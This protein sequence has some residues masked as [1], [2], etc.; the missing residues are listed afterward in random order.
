MRFVKSILIFFISLIT[1]NSGAIN[2][3]DNLYKEFHKWKSV[4]Q[5]D[6][7]AMSPWK[8][9]KQLVIL[10]EDQ[11]TGNSYFIA[12]AD[13]KLIGMSVTQG[14]SS[15]YLLDINMDSI[16]DTKSSFFYMSYKFI[17]S[18]TKIVSQDTSVLRIFNHFYSISMQADE[19]T[20]LNKEE[21]E[22]FKSFFDDTS[23]ANR[24]L[25]Y[26]FS[27]YQRLITGSENKQEHSPGELCIPI[28]KS[29]VDECYLVYKKIPQLACIYRVE[30]LL[31]EKKLADQARREVTTYLKTYPDCIPLQVYDY[32]LEQDQKLK[33]QKLN[34]LK[35]NHSN[36]WMVKQL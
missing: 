5:T 26:L 4:K 1:S 3:G 21:V 2:I 30:S 6:C 33:M 29:L 17:R 12:T 8:E 25:I 34:A 24:H 35:Q 9:E 13:K 15:Y 7:P 14:G 19:L 10:Y 11:S 32:Q 23:L 22:F 31:T 18:K 16:I 28:A 27:T 20:E 36:H